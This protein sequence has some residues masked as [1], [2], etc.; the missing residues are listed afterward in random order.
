MESQTKKTILFSVFV[1]MS[2]F[3]SVAH[4]SVLS[5]EFNDPTGDTTRAHGTDII[6][7]TTIFDN[8]TGSYTTTLFTT[9]DRPFD[10]R[11]VINLN[12]V[13]PDTPDF[14]EEKSYFFDNLNEFSNQPVSTTIELT[15]YDASLLYWKAGDRVALSSIPFGI[16]SNST[17]H[18]FSSNMT[19]YS[20]FWE[21]STDTFPLNEIAIIQAVPV[22]A[23][24]WLF[25]SG[26]IFL[27]NLRK[28]A[29]SQR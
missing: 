6:R 13:N 17:P 19:D 16:P 18:T 20:T 1:L 27:I 14:S 22:P 12:M 8:S 9:P 25:S 28:R 23:S 3:Y 26:L 4:G 29:A 5:F 21:A 10:D 7:I 11:F 24:V 2:N 15:G